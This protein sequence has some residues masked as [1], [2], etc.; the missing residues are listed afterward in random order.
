MKHI[1]LFVEDQSGKIML[2]HLIP[3]MLDQI[4]I[5]DVTFKIN[6][7]KGI[8]RISKKQTSAK[9]IKARQLMDNLPKIINGC[10]NAYNS[11]PKDYQG[12]V[13]IICDLDKNDKK[14]FLKKLDELLESC[15][16]KPPTFFCLAIEEGEAW[17]LGDR[18]AVMTAFP[19]ANEKLLNSYKQDSIC[20]T[21]ETL[22]AIVGFDY[23][24]KS[25][26]E[27]GKE[28]C[29]WADSI[30]PHI[31]LKRNKSPSFQYLLATVK[32]IGL[33]T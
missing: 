13:I 16:N 22:A 11:W 7:Y 20:D 8:G 9:A 27:I 18:K 4:G 28:K 30:S 2:E 10:G 19:H 26:P 29:R 5:N 14:I 6:S 24:G 31:N 15:H 1:E 21:W 25:F 3:K 17:L 32:A 23:R 33:G 12:Y